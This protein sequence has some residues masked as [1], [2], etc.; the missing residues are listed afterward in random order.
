M[1][2]AGQSRNAV[3][4]HPAHPAG[5]LEH[6]PPAAF[7]LVMATGIVSIA[8]WMLGFPQVGAGV[9]AVNL[10]AYATIWGWQLARLIRHP[11]ALLGDL[12][13]HDRG[14]DFLTVVAATA[15][16]GSEFHLLLGAD[17]TALALWFVA[18]GLWVV[19]LYAWF[20]A[21]VMVE[22][23][24]SLDRGINGGWFLLTV[25]TQSIA[26]LGSYVADQFPVPEIAIFVCLGFYLLGGM[27]YLW[28][29]SLVLL[30][31]F[32]FRMDR[33]DALGPTY[34][35]NSGAMAI[36][37]LAGARL[38]ATAGPH[39]ESLAHF[40][41]AFNLLFWA[42]ATWWIPLLLLISVWRFFI[43]RFPLRYELGYWS[44]VFP[45]GMYA[46]CTWAYAESSAP[47]SFLKP[48]ARGSLIV[49]WLAWA[50]TALATLNTL[51]RWLLSRH[52]RQ[53][54]PAPERP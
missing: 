4:N 50:L 10:I 33:T 13:S 8:S 47:L 39:V 38:I 15:L 12:G 28:I 46:A 49:A 30:R 26:V 32:F 52:R 21:L 42:T 35:I 45:L 25:S 17:R 41:T 19:L 1:S 5:G 23:K 29:I 36:T 22:P 43:Q 9:F 18:I 37:T 11:K 3:T 34:W 2:Q 20:A 53:A 6:F 16:V 44:M 51:G 31:W 54:D 7:A 24:P 40:L 14:A 27:F 48:I